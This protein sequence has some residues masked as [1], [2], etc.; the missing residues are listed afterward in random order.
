[1][2]LT[3]KKVTKK[4]GQAWLTCHYKGKYAALIHVIDSNLADQV[5]SA[6]EVSIDCGSKPQ[7]AR[8]KKAVQVQPIKDDKP[9]WAAF[10]V[11][12]GRSD[13]SAPV[14]RTRFKDKYTDWRSAPYLHK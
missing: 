6:I 4:N 7:A 8:L 10:D 11:M 13:H 9:N 2:E 12:L 5:G 1:M 14:P 3:I